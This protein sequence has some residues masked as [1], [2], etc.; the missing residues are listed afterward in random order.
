MAR[1]PNDPKDQAH[2]PLN[3]TGLAIGLAI[4]VA[5]GLLTLDS[6]AAGIGLGIGLGLLF[7]YVLRDSGSA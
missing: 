2:S 1:S 4:G 6:I 7:S 3:L 5:V